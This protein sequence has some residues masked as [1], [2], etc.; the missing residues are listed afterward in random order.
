MI[1]HERASQRDLLPLTAGQLVAVL[2]PAAQHGVQLLREL[3]DDGARAGAIDCRVDTG[4]VLDGAHLAQADVLQGGELVPH[5]V[6]EEHADAVA[7]VPR[8]EVA[9]V[10]SSVRDGTLGRIVEAQQQ[11]DERRLAGAVVAHQRQLLARLDA[12][13]H[14]VQ[15]LAVAAG[16]TEGHL[17]E[18]DQLRAPLR[19]ARGARA[20]RFAGGGDVQVTEQVGDE[21]P[22]LVEAADGGERRLDGGL[23][24]PEGGQVQGQIAQRDAG[25]CRP[26]GHEQV[27]GVE[28][29]QRKRAQEESGRALAP[30]EPP[31]LGVELVEQGA[32]AAEH[33]RRQAED[34]HLLHVR[35]AGEDPFQVVL[36]PALRGPPGVEPERLARK[37]RLGEEGGERGGDDHQR[38]PPR[39]AGE[40]RRVGD[41]D[42]QLLAQRSELQH[43]GE[44]PHAR[45]AP[46]VLHLVVGVRVLEV[47]QLEG[48]GLLQDQGVD[49]VAQGGAHQVAEQ[50]LAP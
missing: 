6:L 4:A 45:L 19:R 18:L 25:P 21:Q 23:S 28:G 14:P 20:R 22:V 11:L 2:E 40:Q 49:V 36:P 48:R 43:Q 8:I 5:V 13:V 33:Q 44:R 26:V 46:R 32:V 35:V 3:V 27:R 39:E 29:K 24:L 31:I 38:A 12:Q 1:A 7:Q 9:Q 10:D 37:A 50:R 42:E 16:I 41:Q 15:R 47:A 30:R 34:L 17:A